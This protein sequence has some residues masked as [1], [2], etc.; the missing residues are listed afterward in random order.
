VTTIIADAESLAKLNEKIRAAPRVALDTE[1]HQERSYSARLMVVQLAFEDEVVIVDPLAVPDLRTMVEALGETQVVGHA[2]GGDLRI[3]AERYGYVPSNVFDSQVAASFCGFG[4]AISL[5]D[6]VQSV[7]G[8]RLRKSQTV[9]DW[10]QRPFSAKQIEYLVDDVAYLFQLQDALVE[11]LQ[12]GKRDEWA[13]EE[14]VPLGKLESHRPDATRIYMRLPGAARL[15]R[16]DLAILR[17][18]AQLRDGLARERDVPPKYIFPDDVVTGL[19]SLRPRTIEDL[20]QLRRLE[21]SMLKQFGVQILQAVERAVELPE[22]ELPPRPPRPPSLHRDAIVALLSVLVN[23]LAASHDLPSTLLAPRAA[24][25]RVAR[26]LPKTAEDLATALEL[27][28]WRIE[29]LAEPLLALLWG[30][31]SLAIIGS[32]TDSPRIVTVDRPASQE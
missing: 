5:L 23:S 18:L 28:P 8:V 4:P 22:E 24:L 20:K 9:S 13:T 10:S 27:S 21:H 16:R 2:L 1:F 30:R 19:V 17:E 32:E 14:M 25:E 29:L 15:G 7:T 26:D 3:F 31:T 12:R 6:L 11:R